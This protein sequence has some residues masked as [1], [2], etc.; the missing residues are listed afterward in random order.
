MQLHR[1]RRGALAPDLRPPSI[2]GPGASCPV[3]GPTGADGDARFLQLCDRFR[4]VRGVRFVRG[5]PG[6]AV[7]GSPLPHD[8]CG[9]AWAL[10][11]ARVRS[12]P[13]TGRMPPFFPP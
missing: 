7:R 13:G 1:S 10:R 11:C 3:L 12:C 4:E 9:C 5:R 8:C 6:H 2:V